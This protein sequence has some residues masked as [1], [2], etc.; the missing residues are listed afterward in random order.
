MKPCTDK[1][2][3]EALTAEALINEGAADN[4]DLTVESP[5]EVWMDITT[6]K[7]DGQQ[8][9]MQQQYKAVG[10]LTVLMRMKELF[11]K[12]TK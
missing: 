11:G 7:A 2:L 4:L 9:L 3:R 1:N 6:E 8:M 5:F 12:G 10:D